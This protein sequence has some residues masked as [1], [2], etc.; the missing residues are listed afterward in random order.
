MCRQADNAPVLALGVHDFSPGGDG[1]SRTPLV[2]VA[3]RQ[4]L[5]APCAHATQHS[6]LLLLDDTQLPCSP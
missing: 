2:L 5:A 3:D 6:T 1:S 4:L